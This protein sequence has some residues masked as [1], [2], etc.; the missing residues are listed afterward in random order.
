[1]N[2]EKKKKPAIIFFANGVVDPTAEVVVSRNIL[3]VFES[4]EFAARDSNKFRSLAPLIRKKHEIV[5]RV[6]IETFVGP[7]RDDAW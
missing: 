7:C 6:V 1:M 4:I 2:K 5:N 3:M